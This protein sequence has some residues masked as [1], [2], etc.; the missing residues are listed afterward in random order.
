MQTC[1]WRA[2]RLNYTAISSVRDDYLSSPEAKVDID[3]FRRKIGRKRKD[4]LSENQD[5]MDSRRVIKA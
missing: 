5:T 1:T 2:D 3:Y 4:Q